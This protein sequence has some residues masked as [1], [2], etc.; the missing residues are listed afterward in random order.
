[1]TNNFHNDLELGLKYESRARDRIVD[2][3]SYRII[4]VSAGNE[5]RY[6]FKAL[7][8]KT[9]EKIRYE[10][11]TTKQ[12][13]NTIFVEYQYKNKPS[14]INSTTANYY[15]FVDVSDDEQYY[16]IKTSLLKQIIEKHTM[17]IAPNYCKNAWGYI[18]DK[19]I[20]IGSSIIL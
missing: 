12:Q 15:I 18:I 2:K 17:K 8:E 1:M 4:K 10:V 16:L 19:D 6:D 13:Y 3:Y 20:I 5:P 9:N 11:K 7:N 14:G